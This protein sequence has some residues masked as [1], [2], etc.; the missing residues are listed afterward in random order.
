MISVRGK[1][2][3][4]VISF[5]ALQ[6]ILQSQTQQLINDLRMQNP[7][8]T[9]NNIITAPQDEI[10]FEDLG[11]W[12]DQI[13]VE[14]FPMETEEALVTEAMKS[15]QNKL[16]LA[17]LAAW[18]QNKA[19]EEV[20][21]LVDQIEANEQVQDDELDFEILP[22]GE[23]PKPRNRG[24]NRPNGNMG[25]PGLKSWDDKGNDLEEVKSRLELV[26]N[27]IE[28]VAA[29]IIDN[30]AKN[31]TLEDKEV[32]DR[33]ELVAEMVGFNMNATDMKSGS[34]EFFPRKYFGLL[35]NSDWILCKVFI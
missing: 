6:E 5:S 12:Q 9:D 22:M 7:A 19:S 15:W 23:D 18:M 2:L 4:I 3:L 11:L 14:P 32:K 10:T 17:K 33:A 35:C 1:F 20:Q 27:R 29:T 26:K 25:K 16:H 30:E 31:D 28:T 24:I 8:I 13:A 34:F 21:D